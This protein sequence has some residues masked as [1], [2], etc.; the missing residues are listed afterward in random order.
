MALT[1][2]PGSKWWIET[3]DITFEIT[4]TYNKTAVIA[5]IQAIR[6]TLTR[7]P[8]ATQ[9]ATDV[10]SIN[11]AVNNTAWT[12]TRKARVAAL[13]QAMFIAYQME[14]RVVEAARLQAKLDA[15]IA[16]RDRLV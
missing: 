12:E 1:R 3:D 13:A 7:Y 9:D 11:T 6:D 10:A 16:L 14:P 15:L 8:D 5:D 2:L 4:G